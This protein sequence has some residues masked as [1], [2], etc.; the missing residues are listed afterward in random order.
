MKQPIARGADAIE[1]AAA[2]LRV[3]PVGR[4]S[5]LDKLEGAKLKSV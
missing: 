5:R 1:L 3:G 2:D 4:V